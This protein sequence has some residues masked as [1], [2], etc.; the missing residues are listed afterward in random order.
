M[1][2]SGCAVGPDY[3]VAKVAVP[4]TFK[5]AA[6]GWKAAQPAD[7]QDRGAW[8]AIF[9]DP[10]LDAL[11]AQVANANQTVAGFAAAWNQ[12]RALVSEA[13]AAYFPTVGV[14]ASASRS[15]DSS[16]GI[17]VNNGVLSGGG[18]NINNAFAVGLDAT[19]EPDLWGQ[20]SREVGSE[21]AGAQAAAADLANAR[22]SAQGTLAQDYFQLRALD[23]SQK[24]LDDTVVS[25]EKSLELTRNRY[26]QGVDA[27]ADIVQAQTQ[28]AKRAGRRDR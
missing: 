7:R 11:E 23:A 24:L 28:P 22:L 4:A 8:W 26:A 5:E 19:W 10:Q 18:G 13:R 16:R 27:R 20:V 2:L 6:P 15:K 14:S 21:K 25:Y 3:K 9:N 12:A 1:T 17:T